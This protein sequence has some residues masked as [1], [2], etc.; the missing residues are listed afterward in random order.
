[1]VRKLTWLLAITGLC[2]TVL[3]APSRAQDE[4]KVVPTKE[5]V[6]LERMQKLMQAYDLAEQGRKKKAPEYLITA[7]G[8]LLHLSP[9]KDLQEMKPQEAKPIGDQKAGSDK[10]VKSP[11]L[12]EQSESLFKDALDMGKFQGAKVDTL[13]KLVKERETSDKEEYGVIGGPRQISR[14][15][16]NGQIYAFHI[17]LDAK[18]PTNWAYRSTVPLIV[19]VVHDEISNP[20]YFGTA[21]SGG[22]QI[23]P[24]GHLNAKYTATLT[25]RIRN[26]SGRPAQYQMMFQ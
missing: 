11:T 2:L 16:A 25:V 17:K 18:S 21:M 5:E 8:I 10:E 3:T 19:S 15:L 9:I 23:L 24:G 4:K 14:T 26:V 20:Y 7:A 6:R 12:L 22:R 13:I 1:M